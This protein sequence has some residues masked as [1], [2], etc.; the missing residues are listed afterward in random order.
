V[1]D[2]G[3]TDDSQAIAASMGARVVHVEAKGYGN[4]PHGGIVA[5]RGQYVIMGDADDSYDFTR[6]DPSLKIT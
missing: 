2:N 3:S 4:C 1:A 6:L 5:A